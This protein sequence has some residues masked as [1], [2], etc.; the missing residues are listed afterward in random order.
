MVPVTERALLLEEIPVMGS[1]YAGRCRFSATKKLR[2]AVSEGL[3]KGGVRDLLR[4]AGWKPGASENCGD[5]TYFWS[6]PARSTSTDMTCSEAAN[7][8]GSGRLP[9]LAATIDGEVRYLPAMAM[10]GTPSIL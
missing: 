8:A 1:P 2:Y 7:S 3:G 9:T 4:C 10:V 5:K 6:L